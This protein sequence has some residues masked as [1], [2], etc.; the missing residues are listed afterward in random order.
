MPPQK[1]DSK[2]PEDAGY[3]DS[4]GDSYREQLKAR[5]HRLAAKAEPPEEAM[6]IEDCE[7]RHHERERE[8]HYARPIQHIG[9]HSS[10][11]QVDNAAA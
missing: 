3:D 5:E 2:R 6:G 8:K 4:P 11:L 7:T 1:G 10:Q 9:V